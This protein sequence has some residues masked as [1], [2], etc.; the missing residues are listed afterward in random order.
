MRQ[1]TVWSILED[2][3]WRVF[4]LYNNI[5]V[6]FYKTIGFIFSNMLKGLVKNIL[7]LYSF[8]FLKA[9]Y[10]TFGNLFGGITHTVLSW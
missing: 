2:K 7:F 5:H 8:P 6:Y 3:R 1:T 10:Q 9:T 4:A